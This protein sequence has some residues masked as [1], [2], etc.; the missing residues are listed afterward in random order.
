ML[1]QL[2][3]STNLFSPLNSVLTDVQWNACWFKLQHNKCIVFFSSILII[4]LC[5][6]TWILCGWN[7]KSTFCFTWLQTCEM[8]H[9]PSLSFRKRAKNQFL[10][11]ALLF[12]LSGAVLTLPKSCKCLLHTFVSRY[13]SYILVM[14][15]E[16]DSS[17]QTCVCHLSASSHSFQYLKTKTGNSYL[18]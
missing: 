16:T 4:W 11:I 17:C 1:W 14:L 8:C 6:Q 13:V 5:Y 18:K 2:K 10:V 15:F 3:L 9:N 12:Y 7:S